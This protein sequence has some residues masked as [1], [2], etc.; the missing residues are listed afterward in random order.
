M[1]DHITLPLDVAI[2][3]VL[4]GLSV[5]W[6]L[7]FTVGAWWASAP[8]DRTERRADCCSKKVTA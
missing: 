8:R 6:S 3:L 4:I 7:A 1:P 2:A 5:C